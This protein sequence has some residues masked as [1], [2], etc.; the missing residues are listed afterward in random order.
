MIEVPT[1]D[2]QAGDTGKLH[3]QAQEKLSLR[4]KPHRRSSLL[5]FLEG[6]R[7]STDWVR[8]TLAG[9]SICFT[10]FTNS[11]VDLNQKHAPTYTE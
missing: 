8:P 9:E 6:V 1:Q 2:R 4:S 3:I 5:A 10:Q 7:P 11:G